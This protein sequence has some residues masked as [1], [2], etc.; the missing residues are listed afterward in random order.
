MTVKTGGGTS[1]V[2]REEERE[3]KRKDTRGCKGDLMLFLLCSCLMAIFGWACGR[4]I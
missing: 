4:L 1:R 2:N 3:K